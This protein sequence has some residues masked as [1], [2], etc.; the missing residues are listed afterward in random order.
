MRKEIHKIEFE[1]N[2]LYKLSTSFY[3]TGNV[4]V[5][6]KIKSIANSLLNS[7]GIIEQEYADQIKREFDR[8][9]QNS[10]NVLNGVFAGMK[11]K[12]QE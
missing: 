6:E 8:A 12:E 2:K 3:N 10:Q 9:E 5:A 4:I 11:L 1:A 7:A